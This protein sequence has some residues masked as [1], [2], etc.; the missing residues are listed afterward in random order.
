MK[1]AYGITV[2][3]GAT[4]DSLNSARGWT[5][6]D[7]AGARITEAVI[8]AKRFSE[9]RIV[10]AGATNSAMG[11]ASSEALRARGLIA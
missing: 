2:L 4:S 11:G 5:V 9:A 1:P 10:C 8:L 6:F 3:G 7:E